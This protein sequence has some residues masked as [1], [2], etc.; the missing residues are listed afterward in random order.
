MREQPLLRSVVCGVRLSAGLFVTWE[1]Q[2]TK[3]MF[4]TAAGMR[5]A[6]HLGCETSGGSHTEGKV[7]EVHLFGVRQLSPLIAKDLISGGLQVQGQQEL[8]LQDIICLILR[9]SLNSFSA[10][11]LP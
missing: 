2:K 9:A 7:P 6:L 4:F 11:G 10:I 8:E 3:L 1:R 5:E